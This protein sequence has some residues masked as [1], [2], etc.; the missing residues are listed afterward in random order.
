MAVSIS[1]LIL[2]K[3]PRE[4]DFPSPGFSPVLPVSAAFAASGSIITSV[5]NLDSFS[6]NIETTR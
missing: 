1:S 4:V 3:S 2:A 6:H 5:F